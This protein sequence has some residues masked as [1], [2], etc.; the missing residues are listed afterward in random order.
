MNAVQQ[1]KRKHDMDALLRVLAPK[2]EANVK[3]RRK[4]EAAKARSEAV[5]RRLND[6]LA[7][8]DIP[9]RVV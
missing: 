3:A 2:M 7:R 9:L 4:R 5:K 1:I 8:R 6:A